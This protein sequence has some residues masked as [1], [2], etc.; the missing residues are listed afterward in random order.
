MPSIRKSPFF[1]IRFIALLLCFT[2]LIEQSGFAQVAGQLDISGYLNSFIAALNRNKSQ[3]LHLRYISYDRINNSLKIILDKGNLVNADNSLLKSSARKSLEHF[4]VG[5]SLPDE[6]FWVNLKPDSENEIMADD[7]SRTDFGKV[8]LEADLQLKKDLAHFTFP[9]TPE[10]SEYWDR[11]Y[12]KI[13]EEYGQTDRG[14]TVN[15]RIWITPGEIIISE[16]GNGA[17]IYKANLNVLTEEAYLKGRYRHQNE[18]SRARA[19]NEYS[20]SLMREL[21]LPRIINDVNT[22]EKYAPLRQAYYSLILAQWFKRKFYGQG[23][24][25]SY[26]INKKN[27]TGITS[28]RPWSKYSYFKQYQKSYRQ[29]EYDL[30]VNIFNLYGQTIRTYSSGGVDFTGILKDPDLTQ[31]K[32]ISVP[33]FDIPSSEHTVLLD[34]TNTPVTTPEQPYFGNT[35]NIQP[36]IQPASSP[37]G[38]L[39]EGKISAEVSARIAEL[40]ALQKDH[41]KA[42]E[43]AWQDAQR[44]A[45]ASLEIEKRLKALSNTRPPVGLKDKATH[46]KSSVRLKRK[47]LTRVMYA[48]L[49]VSIAFSSLGTVSCTTFGR[50]ADSYISQQ[51]VRQ[52]EKGAAAATYNNPDTLLPVDKQAPQDMPQDEALSP[53]YEIIKMGNSQ[54]TK[55]IS[56]LQ[57]VLRQYDDSNWDGLTL[58]TMLKTDYP[59][60]QAD[61][62]PAFTAEIS[63]GK[64]FEFL[65]D[66][67]VHL[68]ALYNEPDPSRRAA[69]AWALGKMKPALDKAAGG[70]ITKRFIIDDLTQALLKD[71]D[72]YVRSAAAWALGQY[73]D[74][75]NPVIGTAS[76]DVRVKALSQAINDKEWLVRYYA[77]IALASSKDPRIIQSIL[78]LLATEDNP[79]VLDITV[80]TALRIKGPSAVLPVI[81]A[82]EKLKF[83]TSQDQVLF[84]INSR[85]W[86][87]IA[88]GLS[89]FGGQSMQ[90]KR[91]VVFSFIKAIQYLQERQDVSD[92]YEVINSNYLPLFERLVSQLKIVRAE[93]EPDLQV[94]DSRIARALLNMI[95]PP[96]A[97]QISQLSSLGDTEKSYNKMIASYAGENAA[98]SEEIKSLEEKMDRSALCSIFLFDRASTVRRVLAADAISR[99]GDLSSTRA[100]FAGLKDSH[101]AVR[102]VAARALRDYAIRQQFV[103]TGKDGS[104]AKALKNAATDKDWMVTSYL[105]DILRSIG[106]SDALEVV[107]DILQSK[108][109]LINKI[110]MES[111]SSFSQEASAQSQL[112]IHL[113]DTQVSDYPTVINALEAAKDVLSASDDPLLTDAVINVLLKV[114]ANPEDYATYSAIRGKSIDCLRQSKSSVERLTE[115]VKEE[116]TRNDY[117]GINTI[118]GILQELLNKDEFNAW[119]QNINQA[120]Q[121]A[122]TDTQ[123]GDQFSSLITVIFNVNEPADVRIDALKKV[124][125]DFTGTGNIPLTSY[126]LKLIETEPNSDISREAIS[127]VLGINTQGGVLTH[128]IGQDP[129]VDTFVKVADDASRPYDL[130]REAIRA[131][132]KSASPEAAEPLTRIVYSTAGTSLGLDSIDAASELLGSVEEKGLLD[133]FVFAFVDRLDLEPDAI[134]ANSQII[135]TSS[136]LI[137]ALAKNNDYVFS[138]LTQKTR[139]ELSQPQQAQSETKI[140]NI[141]YLASLLDSEKFYELAALVHQRSAAQLRNTDND[142]LPVGNSFAESLDLLGQLSDKNPVEV[143]LQTLSQLESI[144]GKFYLNPVMLKEIRQALNDPDENIR[145]AA[146][147]VYSK[148]NINLIAHAPNTNVDVDYLSN[149]IDKPG[150][151]FYERLSRITALGRTVSPYA[152]RPL[153]NAYYALLQIYP[154]MERAPSGERENLE[155]AIM[156]ALERMGQSAASELK[157]ALTVR[158]NNGGLSFQDFKPMTILNELDRNAYD[159]LIGKTGLTP[160]SQ[161]ISQSAEPSVS[162]SVTPGSVSSHKL[163]APQDQNIPNVIPNNSVP[164]AA[165][166]LH[167]S[168][169]PGSKPPDDPLKHSGSS[170]ASQNSVLDISRFAPG[171]FPFDTE[172]ETFVMQLKDYAQVLASGEWEKS[173]RASNVSVIVESL[174]KDGNP[175]VRRAA[176]I[177]LGETKDVR[178]VWPLLAVLSD[179]NEYVVAAS[180]WSLSQFES[181][182]NKQDMRIPPLKE[183]LERNANPFVGASLAFT[184]GSSGDPEASHLME[185]LL[186]KDENVIVR[187]YAADSARNLVQKFKDPSLIRALLDTAK[188][189]Y[190]SD[191]LSRIGIGYKFG[192]A[193]QAAFDS[194]VFI[195]NQ[196]ELR[197]LLV[198]VL[199]EDLG[200]EL[201]SQVNSVFV[202]NDVYSQLLTKFSPDTSNKLWG[203]MFLI[204]VKYWSPIVIGALLGI[205]SL[206]ILSFLFFKKVIRG[207]P[208][209]I[210]QVDKDEILKR[211]QAEFFDGPAKPNIGNKKKSRNRYRPAGTA[212]HLDSAAYQAQPLTVDAI[213]KCQELLKRWTSL[214]THESLSE[215]QMSQILRFCYEMINMLP[216]SLAQNGNNLGDYASIINSAMDLMDTTIDKTIKNIRMRKN[217]QDNGKLNLYAMECIEMGRYFADY[218][219]ALGCMVDLHINAG[220]QPADKQSAERIWWHELWGIEAIG[221]SAKDNLAYLLQKIHLRGNEIVPQLYADGIDKNEYRELVEEYS[222]KIKPSAANQTTDLGISQYWTKRK[223]LTRVVPV[224]VSIGLGLLSLVLG[225]P[226]LIANFGFAEFIFYIFKGF[227]TTF[228]GFVIST[229]LSW[230]YIQK[231]WREELQTYS[232]RYAKLDNYEAMLIK[233]SPTAEEFRD[234]KHRQKMFTE[235]ARNLINA[236][237]MELDLTAS[238]SADLI[239]LNTGFRKE[240]ASMLGNMLLKEGLVRQ[241]TPIFAI[242]DDTDGSNSWRSGDAFVKIYSYLEPE[243]NFLDLLNTLKSDT[244]I[245]NLNKENLIVSQ[246]RFGKKVK[247]LRIVI[248]NAGKP[249]VEGMMNPFPIPELKFKSMALNPFQLALGNGYRVAQILQSQ[250]KA[251]VVMLNADGTYVGPVREFK[252]EF[253]L[254]SSWVSQEYMQEQELGLLIYDNNDHIRKYYEKFDIERIKNWLEREI[255]AGRYDMR[256]IHK[257]QMVISTAI[258]VSSF[259]NET[260][261]K[262]FRDTLKEIADYVEQKK[263]GKNFPFRIF[264]DI[265]IPLIMMSQEENIYTYME[266]RIKDAKEFL[267]KESGVSSLNEDDLRDFYLGI[268][269][270][271][272]KKYP[273]DKPFVFNL[274]VP[275]PHES[276]YSRGATGDSYVNQDN[277]AKSGRG[278]GAGLAEL[279]ELI[280]EQ[281]THEQAAK[282]A[283]AK[284]QEE[285]EAI[286]KIK[287]E[288]SKLTAQRE[289]SASSPVRSFGSGRQPLQ[290]RPDLENG[291]NLGGIDF[292]NIQPVINRVANFKTVIQDSLIQYKFDPIVSE[293]ESEK[294]NK[295]IKAKIIP[296]AERLKEYLETA[297]GPDN[298]DNCFK[299]V[300]NWLA[301]SFRLEE[302]Y[303][304]PADT[305]MVAMLQLISLK[306]SN[307]I[308]GSS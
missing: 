182:D 199:R 141:L 191:F 239:L 75:T 270:I 161:T 59:L 58:G 229:G 17:Y 112:L 304:K 223:Q 4:F 274:Q 128:A 211:Y 86:D 305:S 68:L 50:P 296:S 3:S 22:S 282:E 249:L 76:V 90:S 174:L 186:I 227:I 172:R 99:V 268:F 9:S 132:G 254:L 202:I 279:S 35:F 259:E 102:S 119:E 51:E 201:K 122:T 220:Y 145:V 179:E 118:R 273:D 264:Q 136:R 56:Y 276:A 15:T 225:L 214:L 163:T 208:K 299:Q 176:A 127:G 39:P 95:E 62:K 263:N 115:L 271:I 5:I 147:R 87:N 184:L 196:A 123:D 97:G 143:R 18:D 206:G 92:K 221:Y 170:L 290:N 48:F 121:P 219:S 1:F 285:A 167:P 49:A 234:K 238:A 277:P 117:Q 188:S 7:L 98:V 183:L 16:D 303:L 180:L 302:E 230:H 166:G 26:L 247:E 280:A 108:N 242:S 173:G 79:Y 213:H 73:N 140:N 146:A 60:G 30:K 308:N 240:K 11:L 207:K 190:R 94:L 84:V 159:T 265:I 103:Y 251:G 137:Q 111:L 267:S 88:H 236:F 193:G 81:R 109:P 20:S 300:N 204:K 185:H 85:V 222:A 171:K 241:D 14:I 114:P 256:N 105:L 217:A 307:E 21:I 38:S 66:G 34:L 41:E 70:G 107:N 160:I 138:L 139:D 155:G 212:K 63:V 65:R 156:L 297:P 43:Q 231:G 275:Y 157:L 194:L 91:Q 177:K 78:N 82:M 42:E 262:Q 12:K 44:H 40:T 55:Q 165:S 6:S 13:E 278:E 162:K 154:Y 287:E 37:I 243:R 33:H 257:R 224:W 52:D 228:L 301:E 181:R 253:T 226:T 29:K 27:L 192:P 151:S 306:L 100:L 32:V 261:F 96:A 175:D 72:P 116:K 246:L 291:N 8:L 258:L 248:I 31:V 144:G 288:L 130:R 25:Y 283:L 168:P 198:E 46:K 64:I 158:A 77:V 129:L 113:L 292:R 131:L 245:V 150:M 250:A 61:T 2:L 10:G 289:P 47:F 197:P 24:L 216:I 272:E 71:K 237:S 142:P 293:Q 93:V 252:D 294:I 269:K 36:A 281:Q 210:S 215:A 104:L 203:T 110:V 135:E 120:G 80:R 126:L 189:D 169:P 74:T 209:L 89:D 286:A 244:N 69:A 148:I 101:P 152:A 83:D 149:G 195:G 298:Y 233:Y 255:L 218:F 295:L 153:L 187:V 23:G 266:A 67:A 45:Q 133:A 125:S 260:H 178:A 124:S 164:A 106:G 54:D 19:V 205:L 53:Y 28:S 57:G 200:K 134:R 235:E 232:D 284:A